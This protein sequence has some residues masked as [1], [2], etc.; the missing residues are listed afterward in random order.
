MKLIPVFILTISL[1]IGVFLFSVNLDKK[2]R[3][4]SYDL[5]TQS[6]ELQAEKALDQMVSNY[7]GVRAFEFFKEKFGQSSPSLTHE[8]GHFLGK[9]LYRERGISAVLVCDF[10]QNWSCFHSLIQVALSA[11]E[12][13]VIKKAGDLCEKNS[14][15]I[16]RCMDAIGHG[17][18]FTNGY[19][20]PGLQKALSQ[21]DE[22]VRAGLCYNGV[23]KEYN[24]RERMPISG[25]STP[26]RQI[27]MD[28]LEP[29]QSVDVRYQSSCYFEQPYWWNTALAKDFTSMGQLC[30]NVS[31]TIRKSCFQGIGRAVLAAS[32]YNSDGSTLKNCAKLPT[33][34]AEGECVLEA[35]SILSG[36]YGEKKYRSENDPYQVPAPTSELCSGLIDL[37][38]SACLAKVR[39]FN[40]NKLGKCN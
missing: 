13:G 19:S 29:C 35:V 5:S 36:T 37:Q 23:F 38:K 22:M 7:G 2:L 40:C 18:L 30:L 21:C 20:Q 32:E 12:K 31:D 15:Q 17:L 9:S 4:Q 10:T 25:E 11:G 26:K 39:E 6:G 33:V 24:D 16:G 1:G 27:P 3:S 34:E 8:L 28:L 14:P